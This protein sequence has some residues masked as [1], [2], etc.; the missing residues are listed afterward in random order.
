MNAGALI[1]GKY[2]LMRP[3][4]KGAMGTVWEATHE[5][6]SRQ[7]AVKLILEPT[8][9]LRLRLIREARAYGALR[10]RNIVEIL[11]VG[12]TDDGDPF[13]VMQ[14]LVG[15]TLADRL[16]R[17]RRLGVPEAARIARDVARALAT[18]HAASIIHRDLKPANI[19]LHDEPGEDTTVV[20]VVDFGVSKNLL[21]SDGLSTVAGGM[22]GSPA[23]MSPEQAAAGTRGPV[24]HRAD[25]WSL[26]VVL[27]E[28][29]T[30]VRPLQGDANTIIAQI[31]AGEIPLVTRFVRTVDPRL[32]SLVARCLDRDL[33][34]RVGSAEDLAVQLQAFTSASM[35]S[36][37]S[38]LGQSAA[39]MSLPYVQPPQSDADVLGSPRGGHPSAPGRD[40]SGPAFPPAR[41]PQ[42]S[43]S[44][45]D[46]SARSPRLQ[47]GSFS[48]A[49]VMP[50]MGDDDDS[51]DQATAKLSPDML[52]AFKPT[53]QAAPQPQPQPQMQP[54]TSGTVPIQSDAAL[55]P[56]QRAPMPSHHEP[57]PAP[58]SFNGPPSGQNAASFG[59]G[60]NW[61][62]ANPTTAKLDP[63]S[64]WAGEGA[65]VTNQGTV[66]IPP[67]FLKSIGAAGG[68]S[69]LAPPP[70]PPPPAHAFGPSPTSSTA[71]LL[72]QNA[73][74]LSGADKAASQ[75]SRR[76]TLLVV[77]SGV[78]VALA[79]LVAVVVGQKVSGGSTPAGSEHAATESTSV[80][81][82]APA[83]VPVPSAE[84]TAV[85]QVA[86][87]PPPSAEPIAPVPS[88]IA[89]AHPSAPAPTVVQK[90][91]AIA[92]SKP[93]GVKPTINAPAA[94]PAKSGKL[95]G[96]LSTPPKKAN[97]KGI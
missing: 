2:R 58:P 31:V 60:D 1:A 87:P 18:A 52:R 57:P 29:L 5:G 37:S 89:T 91:P 74:G 24:D 27:F 65:S 22:V 20:K 51:D 92:T 55:P 15:E 77:G 84:P 63:S 23:Y 75:K 80:P 69:P 17:Q 93:T 19:F 12:Q 13:L 16:S 66:R 62:K 4:G 88:S 44:A 73:G 67:D 39:G 49:P 97:P 53:A 96:F 79:I 86:P 32:A 28:M 94:A 8:D 70:A 36:G 50:G 81:V 95:P 26:G 54:R 41:A 11:D 64:A 56:Y 82:V 34:K 10:H 7:V 72:H 25:L 45:G 40:P 85:A 59:S 42:P 43:V 9:E 14:L 61:P 35:G 38:P 48:A 21:A 47:G 90:A 78:G 3:I 33:A 71:P 6:T 68:A 30:G 76:T 46:P 83:P